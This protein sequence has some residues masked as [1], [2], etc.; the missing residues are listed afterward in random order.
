MNDLVLF[1]EQ[2]KLGII[3]LNRPDKKNALSMELLSDLERIICKLKKSS[4]IKVIII[5]GDSDFFSAGGD[6]SD[7]LKSGGEDAESM[8]IKVQNLFSELALINIPVIA[9]LSGLVYGGG[10]ELALFCDIRIAADNVKLCMP[11]VNFDIIPGAGGITMLSKILGK[12][13]AVYY[14]FT[15]KEIPLN[16]AL[17]TGLV[18]EIVSSAKIEKR[19]LEIASE[20][21]QK[22]IEVLGTIKKL[23]RMGNNQTIGECFIS[24]AKEFRSLLDR[25]G[26]QKIKGFFSDK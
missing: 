20:L 1:E 25:F 23:L 3:R 13:N 15:G 9:Q 24:E 2:N 26:K 7:M 10:L 16:L 18:H 5:K 4:S 12:E 17:N 22:N 14:L 21:S 6:F 11:E 8:S 19:C